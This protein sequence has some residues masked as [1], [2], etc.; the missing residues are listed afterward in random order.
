MNAILTGVAASTLLR[1]ARRRAHLTQA[2]LGDRAG[3]SQAEV[4]R[5]ERA[6]ANPTAATLERLLR[7][8]GHRLELRRLDAVDETQL[9]ERLELT[10]AERLAA[11]EA[12]QR[13]LIRLTHGARRVSTPAG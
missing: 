13:N 8:T 9:R 3:L 1:T 5:L 10:P 7:A 2:Q 11:F 4:A 6:G 12:S